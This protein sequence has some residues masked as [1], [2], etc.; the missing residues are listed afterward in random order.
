M[1]SSGSSLRRL[2]TEAAMIIASIL[3][4]FAIDRGFEGY[5]QT[6]EETAILSGLKAELTS[7]RGGLQRHMQ[8]YERWENS[9]TKIRTYLHQ[10]PERAGETAPEIISALRMLYA[11]PTFD[12]STATLDVIEASGRGTVVTDHELRTFIAE[13]RVHAED[14][15]DQQYVLQRSREAILWPLLVELNIEAPRPG[16]SAQG[17]RPEHGPHR[18]WDARSDIR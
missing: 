7:S 6:E 1:E 17:V 15:L 3:L 9:I 4:A 10:D 8:W 13:W 14:A 11:N 2:G 12:P 16:R 18:V 5:Q